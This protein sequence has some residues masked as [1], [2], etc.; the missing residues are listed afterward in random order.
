MQCHWKWEEEFEG[1]KNKWPCKMETLPADNGVEM[2]PSRLLNPGIDRLNL[3]S[4][5][6]PQK[7][8]FKV[9]WTKQRKEVMRA[10]KMGFKNKYTW[11]AILP[12]GL[13]TNTKSSSEVLCTGGP[14]HIPECHLDSGNLGT[15]ATQVIPQ[16][17]QIS[18]FTKCKRMCPTYKAWALGTEMHGRGHLSV[19]TRCMQVCLDTSAWTRVD[20]VV[21]L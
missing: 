1:D 8:V 18:H 2:F 3:T 20:A 13:G 16:P 7:T 11:K 21:P 6:S 15:L 4:K 17:F 12:H 14:L 5:S 10:L 9:K 19:Q